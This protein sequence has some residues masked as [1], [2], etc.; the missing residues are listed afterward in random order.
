MLLAGFGLA[1]KR[2][3]NLEEKAEIESTINT[4][5]N[6]WADITHQLTKGKTF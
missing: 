1:R 3:P 6:S 4:V 5:I 2:F